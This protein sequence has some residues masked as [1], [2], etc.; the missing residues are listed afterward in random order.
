MRALADAL[1]ERLGVR[2]DDRRPGGR[3][4]AALRRERGGAPVRPAA[5]CRSG[6]MLDWVA[7]WVAR[8][9]AS[10]AKPTKFEVRDGTF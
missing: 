8:G 4:R 7:D 1:G 9:G 6:P 3:D 10:F 5:R 2:G